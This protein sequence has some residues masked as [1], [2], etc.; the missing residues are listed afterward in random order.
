VPVLPA[1][2]LVHFYATPEGLAQSLSGF[3]AE[4]LRRGESVI[5][6]ARPEHRRAVD[7]ALREAG[8]D[9]AAEV[10][11]GRYR[12]L[13]V[14]ETLETLL[15]DGRVSP[16]LFHS[17]ARAMVDEARRRTGAVHVYGELV[18]TLVARGDIVGAL[19]LEDLWAD[20]LREAPFPLICGYPR[21]VLEGDLAGVIDGVASIHDA[22]VSAR[23]A[24]R[25][26]PGAVVD[27]VLGPDATGTA[28]EHVRKVLTTWGQDEPGH[29]DEASLVVSELVGTASRQG[30]RQVALSLTFDEL[31]VVV[32]LLDDSLDDAAT[33]EEDLA[34]AG[35]SF[36]VLGALAAGWGVE[37]LSGGT[38]V[39]ARLH[40]SP[41]A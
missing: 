27:L 19:Q 35:R 14:T 5:V 39:W 11:A 37:H 36:A 31:G 25:R 32:S 6:V 21:E 34:D 15:E 41:A 2:H 18:S 12:S 8:V 13:D 40:R 7:A 23:T 22:F 1:A 16:R 33:A 28:R 26:A 9:L 10:R 17:R 29:L 24:A 20:F 4:P 30:S 38:R 3:F